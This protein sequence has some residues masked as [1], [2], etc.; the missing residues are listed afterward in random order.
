MTKEEFKTFWTL[1]YPDTIPIS[2][3]FK[4]D[5]SQKWFRIHSLPESKRYPESENEWGILLERQNQIITDLFGENEKILLVTGEY[6]WG[7]RTTF[8]TDEEEVFKPYKFLRL[9][10]IDMFEY[11]SDD[12]DKGEIYRP[13]FAEIIWNLNHYNKLLREIAINNVSAF[14]VSI[15]KNIIVV[16]YD[17]GIDFIFKDSE[18]RDFYKEK[19]KDW[20]SER[21]DGL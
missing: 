18:T 8:I 16:P 4:N 9:D 14:F 1:T 3:L 13:A 17:G 2:Y 6:N 12:Y 21:E 15:V 5:Y 7:E 20:L 10:N 19:Y 11:N